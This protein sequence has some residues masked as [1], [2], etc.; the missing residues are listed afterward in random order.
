MACPIESSNYAQARPESPTR[1]ALMKDDVSSGPLPSHPFI[2]YHV[3][4]QGSDVRLTLFREG[5]EIRFLRG[6]RAHNDPPAE[7]D[8]KPWWLRPAN[9][10]QIW[11]KL[12]QPHDVRPVY[13]LKVQVPA[14][15]AL[16]PYRNK[17]SLYRN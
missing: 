9:T 14:W 7:E 11:R 12:V 6:T 8:I 1:T 15:A 16:S 5:D 10:Q 17:N 4:Q 3:K 2:T 13:I